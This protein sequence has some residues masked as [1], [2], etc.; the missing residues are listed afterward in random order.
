VRELLATGA[1]ADARAILKRSESERTPSSA[2]YALEA[3]VCLRLGDLKGARK[4]V[5]KGLHSAAGLGVTPVTVELFDLSAD[6]QLARHEAEGARD[7]LDKAYAGARRLGMV[8]RMLD[9]GVRRL[10][11]AEQLRASDPSALK[12]EVAR[13]FGRLMDEDLAENSTLAFELAGELGAEHPDLIVRVAQ[14]A[15][16]PAELRGSALVEALA[17]WDAELGGVLRERRDVAGLLEAGADEGRPARAIWRLTASL[18]AEHS[19]TPKAAAI[20]AATFRR[21]A[22]VYA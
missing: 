4:A 6:L 16:P 17:T 3:I 14:V 18:L 15:D 1:L 10:R 11:L 22:E 9:L 7:A 19:L 12:R 21:P 5:D 20:L 2:L 8:S 13:D